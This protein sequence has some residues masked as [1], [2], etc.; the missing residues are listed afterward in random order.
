MLSFFLKCMSSAPPSLLFF[1]PTTTSDNN[2]KSPPFIQNTRLQLPW[3][4]IL[5]PTP[6]FVPV[7]TFLL[8]PTQKNPRLPFTKNISPEFK[9]ISNTAD[10]LSEKAIHFLL[11]FSTYTPRP[12]I[13]ESNAEGPP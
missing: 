3:L 1:E 6:S 4:S 5:H 9:P 12:C 11:Y 13:P 2:S 10:K 8:P 7:T